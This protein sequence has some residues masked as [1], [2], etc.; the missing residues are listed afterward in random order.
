MAGEGREEEEDVAQGGVGELESLHLLVPQGDGKV[1]GR[2]V[3]V[4]GGV[5][6]W[7]KLSIASPAETMRVDRMKENSNRFEEKK[8]PQQPWHLLKGNFRPAGSRGGEEAGEGEKRKVRSEVE[9]E[10]KKSS[11][12]SKKE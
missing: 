9:K 11:K 8:L 10:G 1:E 12:K 7:I 2:M 6:R 5:K 3:L 4:K